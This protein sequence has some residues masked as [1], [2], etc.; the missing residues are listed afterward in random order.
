[1]TPAQQELRTEREAIMK[2]ECATMAEIEAVWKSYP[3]YYG[4]CETEITQQELI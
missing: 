2:A 1:M 3:E 4:I